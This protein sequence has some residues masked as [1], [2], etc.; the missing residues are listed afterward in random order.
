MVAGGIL[1]ERKETG[2][3]F[4]GIRTE[5]LTELAKRIAGFTAWGS[6]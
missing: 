2:M 1:T 4:Y 5:T 3:K 6:D